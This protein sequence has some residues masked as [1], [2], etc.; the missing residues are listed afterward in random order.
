MTG[1]DI[2][3]A[4]NGAKVNQADLAEALGLVHRTSLTDIESGAI[5]V[6]SAWALKAIGT[7]SGLSANKE[8][9]T[10]A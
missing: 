4:R 6:T 3:R 9:T 7:I 2:K 10:A 8:R 5:E 1:G